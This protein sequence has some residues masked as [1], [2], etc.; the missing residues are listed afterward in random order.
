MIFIVFLVVSV[1]SILTVYLLARLGS[2]PAQSVIEVI[3]GQ[4][5]STLQQK[6]RTYEQKIST[7]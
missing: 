2:A 6:R 7:R 1:Y 3:K 5:R 4:K